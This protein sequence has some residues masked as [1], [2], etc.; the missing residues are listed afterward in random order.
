MSSYDIFADQY[1]LLVNRKSGAPQ[2]AYSYIEEQLSAL[3]NLIGLTVCDIGCGQGELSIRLTARGAQV[4][5]V[6]ISERLLAIAE[7]KSDRVTWLKEDAMSLS[8][9]PDNHFDAVVSSLMLMDVPDFRNVFEAAWRVLKPGG[10]FIWV[11]MHPC[12]QSPF[13]HPLEDGGRKVQMY[14]PQFWRSLGTGTIR[15]TVG[16]YHRPV[17]EY[18]NAFMETGFSIIRFEEPGAEQ[19]HDT[20][21]MLFSGIGLKEA[22]WW[23]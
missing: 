7:R 3:E 20:V 8:Q 19:C 9:L 12:F 10:I 21:P 6:D 16:A 5:G 14:A 23:D 17:T 15:S 13:S 4:T 11:I 18:I 22:Q 2:Q 1:D